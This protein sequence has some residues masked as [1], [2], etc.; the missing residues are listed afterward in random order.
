M[1]FSILDNANCQV[2]A[3]IL[4][5]RGLT[6][7]SVLL[8]SVSDGNADKWSG[9]LWLWRSLDQ[10]LDVAKCVAC[11]DIPVGVVGFAPRDPEPKQV[12]TAW[13]QGP[14]EVLE[15]TVDEEGGKQYFATV[16]DG[17]AQGNQVTAFDYSS[18]ADMPITGTSKGM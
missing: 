12:I 9:S 17:R 10:A 4:S 15:L 3:L 8:N 18:E 1:S 16:A 2:I 14:V 6:D 5:S 7:G 13:V 11:I